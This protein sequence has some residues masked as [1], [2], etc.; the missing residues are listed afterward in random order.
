MLVRDEAYVVPSAENAVVMAIGFA[1][2]K[3]LELET[4]PMNPKLIE[5]EKSH[6][7]W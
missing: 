7:I 5:R 6:C 4:F 2:Q 3:D 1:S